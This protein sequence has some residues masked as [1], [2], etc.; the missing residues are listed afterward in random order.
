MSESMTPGSQALSRNSH[1]ASVATVR[2]WSSSPSGTV[3]IVVGLWAAVAAVYWP[4][5]RDLDRLWTSPK[6]EEAFT[7]GYLILAISLW[8]VFRAR[9]KVASAP[10]ERAP[11][12]MFALLALSA[13]WLFCWRA[14]IQEAHELLLPL[15]WYV[16]IAAATGWRRAR[17]LAFPIGYLYFAMPIWSDINGLVQNLSAKMT[18]AL[19]FLT[20]LPAFMQGDYVQLPGGSIEIAGTCSGL[21]ALIVGLAL[22][23]LYG[24]VADVSP[25]RR[26]LWI[27]VM[28]SLSLIVNWIRIFTVITA[29]YYTEMHSSLVRHHYWLGWWLFAGAFAIFLW[30]TGRKSQREPSAV[31]RDAHAPAQGA[32]QMA[33]V[34]VRRLTLTLALLAALPMSA[35]ALDGSRATQNTGIGIEWPSTPADWRRSDEA[36]LGEWTPRF[37]HPGAEALRRYTDADGHAVEIFVVA[38]RIQTQ[39][40]KLLSYWNHL[41]AGAGHLRATAERIA[42]A[43]SGR[44]R[45]LRV[46]DASGGRSLIWMRYR[47]G[48]RPFVEPR[49]SQLWYGLRALV[50]PPISSLTALRTD[51]SNDCRTARIRLAAASRVL[52]PALGRLAVAGN[53]AS[54]P[55]NGIARSE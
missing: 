13:L 37:H 30:W 35:Y 49:L 27:A 51:C 3:A 22:A 6:H 55:A 8:L 36:F 50:N 52:Q 11:S 1:G 17:V 31:D 25:R 54:V 15:I 20:G 4:T 7:H 19:I 2:P 21:H 12:A 9:N 41:L 53:A 46:I 47:I 44:W 48:T 5:A 26:W 43:P 24:Y 34:G 10:L 40:A 23:A 14:A 28:G 45:E 38:Y 29:A 32:S 39:D 18:G 33:S 42:E 16:A